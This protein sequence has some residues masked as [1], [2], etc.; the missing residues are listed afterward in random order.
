[1]FWKMVS[2]AISVGKSWRQRMKV[3][4]NGRKNT[5]RES[6]SLI[7]CCLINIS[8]NVKNEV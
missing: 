2:I 7:S 1:M 4:N 6:G 5:M 8:T 3:I